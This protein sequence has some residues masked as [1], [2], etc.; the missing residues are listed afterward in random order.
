MSKKKV[1]RKHL[2]HLYDYVFM[3]N[4]YTNLWYAVKRDDKDKY[5]NDFE[6]TEKVSHEDINELTK[7]LIKNE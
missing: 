7:F 4:P 1:K 2:L 6:N 3:F 5:Y